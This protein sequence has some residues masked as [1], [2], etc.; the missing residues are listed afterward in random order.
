MK[1]LTDKL[2]K[3][4]TENIE[5]QTLNL[6]NESKLPHIFVKFKPRSHEKRGNEAILNP[7]LLDSGSMVNLLSIKTFNEIGLNKTNIQTCGKYNIKS[8][9]DTVQNCILGTNKVT[10]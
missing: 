6:N 2:Q 5:I 7:I 4:R 3:P 9:T 1:K 10:N 8:I